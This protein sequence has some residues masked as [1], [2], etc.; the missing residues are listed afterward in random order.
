MSEK[1]SN[2]IHN[3]T[4]VEVTINGSKAFSVSVGNITNRFSRNSSE[5]ELVS[6]CRFL[7]RVERVDGQAGQIW[8]MLSME[9]IYINDRISPVFPV[10]DSSNISFEGM[11]NFPRSSYKFLAYC[12]AEKGYQVK[13]DL[14]GVDDETLVA[15][16]LNRNL[17]W[18]EK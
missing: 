12:L 2:A 3:I 18:L 17:F 9:V 14:P 13:C 5:Y 15:E 1:G 16:V 10:L 8:K 6:N 11:G 4:P 7:S